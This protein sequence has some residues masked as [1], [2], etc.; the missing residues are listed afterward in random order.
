MIFSYN[1]FITESLMI[2]MINETHLFAST[3]FLA[4]LRNIKDQSK[5]AAT[6]YQ[7][8]NTN[9]YVND[10]LPQ[11]YIDVGTEDTVTFLSDDK[12][13]K[14]DDR[15][16]SF[17]TRGRGSIRIGRFV[18][19]LL[20]KDEFRR[21]TE[22]TAK[23]VEDFVNLYKAT[24]TNVKFKFTLVEG[25]DIAKWYSS[26]TYVE[27]RGSLGNSCMK[28]KPANYFDIYTKNPESCKLLIYTDDNDKLLGR[29]LVWVLD[30]SPTESKYFMDRVYTV[31]DSDIIKFTNYAKEQ[32]WMHKFYQGASDEYALLFKYDG[33]DFFGKASVKL[34]NIDFGN[35]PYVDTLFFLDEDEKTMS[36]TATKQCYILGS[37][38][39]H[40]EKCDSCNGNGL[41]RCW[42]CGST[43][44]THCNYQSGYRYCNN[45]KMQCGYCDGKNTIT[46]RT[47]RGVGSVKCTDCEGWGEWRCQTCN[48]IGGIGQGRGRRRLPCEDC[49]STGKI[50]CKICKGTAKKE[51]PDCKGSGSSVCT[52]CNGENGQVCPSCEGAAKVKCSN[53]G[54]S[55]KPCSQCVGMFDKVK[56]LIKDDCISNL[57]LSHP[58]G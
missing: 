13:S 14:L 17:S 3:E 34:E 45:G 39:G 52:R 43:G 40:K 37:T 36:N 54:G 46:C 48:G 44:E 30:E 6:L 16:T 10:K 41:N 7:L 8:F 26:S 57:K 53:C 9:Y 29:A 22:F 33:K 15:S 20:G 25:D 1:D 31:G 42:K 5:I 23:D 55:Q 4:R 35:Y 47:C 24:S 21:N 51:C 12:Y 50:V 2:K 32:N 27:Q 49:D 56:D 58:I 38:Y 18:N 28:S 19:A 11:N